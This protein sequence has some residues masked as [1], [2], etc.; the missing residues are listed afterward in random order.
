MSQWPESVVQEVAE[1][2]AVF[3]VGA[4]ASMSCVDGAGNRPPSWTELLDKLANKLDDDKEKK[5]ALKLLRSGR[6]LEAAQVVQDR[7]T[8]AEFSTV[9]NSELKN[10]DYQPSSIHK[11]LL[12]IDPK[13]VVTTNY[14]KIY[15]KQFDST[16]NETGHVVVRYYESHAI[17]ALRSGQRCLF[18]MHGCVDDPTKIV[19]SKTSYFSARKDAPGFFKAIDAL[20]LVSTLIFVGTSFDDPDLQLILENNNVSAKSDHQHYIITQKLAHVSMKNILEKNY[21]IRAFE[22]KKG[23]HEEVA[24]LLK[25][26]SDEVKEWRATHD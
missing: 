10:K 7:I 4:G 12:E 21:N 14:D 24:N 9:I 18:K 1:R 8:A 25:T 26:L 15:E 5:F 23:K 17:N 6:L 13:V 3:V 22:Y 16:P 19:L 11:I 20:F 2:R